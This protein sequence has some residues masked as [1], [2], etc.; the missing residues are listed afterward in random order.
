MRKQF[1][2]QNGRLPYRIAEA[3]SGSVLVLDHFISKEYTRSSLLS[4]NPKVN[5]REGQPVYTYSSY[6]ADLSA[7]HIHK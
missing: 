1:E 2:K 5:E 3:M 7:L 6:L 4:G